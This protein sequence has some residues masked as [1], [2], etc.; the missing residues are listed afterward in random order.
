MNNVAPLLIV[1]ISGNMELQER[2][3]LMEIVAEGIKK[4]A[5]V[6][7]EDCEIIAF[8]QEGRL[9]YPVKKEG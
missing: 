6:I 7:A 5:L 4:G 8:D 1:K 3:N 9:A 2:R